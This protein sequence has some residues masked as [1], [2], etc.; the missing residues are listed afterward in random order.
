MRS[1]PNDPHTA[2][3]SFFETAKT[4]LEEELERPSITTVQALALIAERE[5]FRGRTVR[6]GLYHVM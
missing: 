3:D 6:A 5:A 4:Y 1:D 2:G